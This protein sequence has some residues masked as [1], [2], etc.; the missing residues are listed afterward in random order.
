MQELI[1]K[2][3]K[4]LGKSARYSNLGDDLCL[5]NNKVVFRIKNAANNFKPGCLSSISVKNTARV[6]A[7][8]QE[9][10]ESALVEKICAMASPPIPCELCKANG[11]VLQCRACGG[12]GEKYCDHC[13]NDN[14]CRQCHGTGLHSDGEEVSCYSCGGDKYQ[15]QPVQVLGLHVDARLLR[16]IAEVAP[17]SVIFKPKTN[18]PFYFKND[19]I[20][21]LV[22]PCS[23]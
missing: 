9:T 17:G 11:H 13:E 7:D 8:A 19:T 10:S 6:F 12:D 3:L 21:G 2:I 1:E 14:M 16:I 4:N 22:M 5:T 15:I 23:V 20:S 18:R